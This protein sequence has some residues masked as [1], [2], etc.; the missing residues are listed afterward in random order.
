MQPV[1]V[2]LIAKPSLPCRHGKHER[3]AFAWE[4][5][6]AARVRG[7]T[8]VNADTRPVMCVCACHAEPTGK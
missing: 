1:V 7:V 6:N 8:Y 3:C 2:R 5:P 4:Q